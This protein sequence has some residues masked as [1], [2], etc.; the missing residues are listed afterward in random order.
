MLKSAQSGA[1][2]AIQDVCDAEDRGH[3]EA[4]VKMFGRLYSA[5]FPEAVDAPHLVTRV[6]AG[7]RSERG[8]LIEIEREEVSAA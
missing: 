1:K 8:V 6:R 3:A 4:A 2:K 5:K 7:D